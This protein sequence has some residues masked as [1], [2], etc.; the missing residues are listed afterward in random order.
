MCALSRAEPIPGGRLL[1]A[2]SID[3]ER[4]APLASAGGGMA[5][6]LRRDLRRELDLIRRQSVDAIA[7]QSAFGRKFSNQEI[8]EA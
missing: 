2:C 6:V 5:G 8:T 4:L 1:D 7:A 3:Q